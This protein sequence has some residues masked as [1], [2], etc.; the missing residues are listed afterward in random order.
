MSLALYWARGSQL[1]VNTSIFRGWSLCYNGSYSILL[2]GQPLQNLL[3]SCNRSKLLLGCGLLSNPDI[4]SV[5]GMDYRE[6]VIYNCSENSNCSYTSNGLQWYF[7]ENVA[8]GFANQSDTVTRTMCDTS[9][10]PNP[11][12][13][14]CWHTAAGYDGYRCASTLFN[15]PHNGS[16]WQRVIW[17]AD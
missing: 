13:R 5:V 4:Y 2:N 14:L 3:K 10:T 16:Y 7:S 1:N 11:F 6:N 8:W 9:V 15:F 12:S 17:H